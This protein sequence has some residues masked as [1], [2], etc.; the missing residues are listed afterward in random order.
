MK[1]NLSFT[2]FRSTLP[3]NIFYK[4]PYCGQLNI[5]NNYITLSGSMPGKSVYSKEDK[6]WTYMRS[7]EYLALRLKQIEQTK[8][9][10]YHLD[11]SCINCHKSPAWACY[12]RKVF[13]IFSLI[14]GLLVLSFGVAGIRFGFTFGN[15]WAY[16]IIGIALAFLF[17]SLPLYW[18]RRKR[19]DKKIDELRWDQLPHVTI[20]PKSGTISAEKTNDSS[21]KSKNQKDEITNKKASEVPENTIQYDSLN[22]KQDIQKKTATATS[23]IE[24]QK[25]DMLSQLA[26]KAELNGSSADGEKYI[27]ELKALGFS[28]EQA[29]KLLQEERNIIKRFTKKY[30]LD[31]GF[32]KAWFMGLQQPFFLTYPKTMEDI[33][34][35][36]FFTISEIVKF[37]DEAEW[38]FWNSTGKDL[39][40]EV[41]EEINTW[42]RR[43]KGGAFGIQYC[44]AISRETGIPIELFSK[45]FSHEAN[46][47]NKYKW[48]SGDNSQG[49]MRSTDAG[50]S[51]DSRPY[52]VTLASKNHG[53]QYILHKNNNLIGRS[54]ACDVLFDSVKFISNRHAIIMYENNQWLI[55]DN[56]SRNGTWLNET[57]LEPGVKYVLRSGDI[58]DLAHQEQLEF[59]NYSAIE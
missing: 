22:L 3:Y 36:R 10:N 58:I 7:E 37:I 55:C 41:F 9:R 33:K 57:K 48:G 30:L 13:H 27:L 8:G 20:S 14:I 4:C 11:V 43:G 52:R 47:L 42:R 28:D 32:D 6:S 19:R 1:L 26:A 59:V 56:N 21:T 15:Q 38:H 5:D 50:V 29:K 51:S 40:Q 24:N 23:S 39:S 25:P 18:I 49:I 54:P 12:P 46:H 53:V 44:E 31:S 45:Y 2:R 35:E 34:K 16:I 17:L